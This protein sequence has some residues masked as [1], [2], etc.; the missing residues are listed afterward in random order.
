MENN[1]ATPSEQTP[2]PAG[3]DETRRDFVSSLSSAAMLLGLASSYGTFGVLAGRYLFPARAA[4]KRWMFVGALAEMPAGASVTFRTPSG[5]QIAVTRKADTSA[6]ASTDAG[7]ETSAATDFIALSSICPHL[8]CRVH[9]EAANARF[10]CPCH[11]G[12]F[13]GEGNPTAGPPL[14]AR[15]ALARYPLKVENNLLYIEVP[16]E[17]PG[18]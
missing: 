5:A 1:S 3:E 6:D 11:N 17:I 12:A 4:E 13:D 10:Y 14:D 9:W 15:Q 7:G 18:A 8:G 16:S 2:K